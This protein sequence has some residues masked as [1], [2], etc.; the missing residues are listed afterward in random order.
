MEL[1]KIKLTAVIDSHVGNRGIPWDSLNQ[2]THDA[3]PLHYFVTKT[4][5][6]LTAYDE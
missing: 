6:Y 4:S 2:F 3:H 5:I 1:L